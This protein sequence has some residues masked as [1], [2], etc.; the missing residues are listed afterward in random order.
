MISAALDEEGFDVDEMGEYQNEIFEK[1]EKATV[2]ELKG[3][4]NK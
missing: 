2:E 4:M 1:L 3:R